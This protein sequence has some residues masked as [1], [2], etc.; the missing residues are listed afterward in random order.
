MAA[1]SALAHRVWALGDCR[2]L[3]EHPVHLALQRPG[4]PAL[5]AA[6]FGVDLPL[7]WVVD[8]DELAELGPSP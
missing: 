3:E 6:E 5:D 2:P 1:H 7:E 4:A 8:G